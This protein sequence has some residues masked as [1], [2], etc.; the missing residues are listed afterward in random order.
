ML[1]HMT[2]GM[3]N[4]VESLSFKQM[5]C[6]ACALTQEDAQGNVGLLRME[7]HSYFML[8]YLAAYQLT[9]QHGLLHL[10]LHLLNLQLLK[11]VLLS[12]RCFGLLCLKQLQVDVR[13]SQEPSYTHTA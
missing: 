9:L 2:D 10:L 3:E 4:Y 13:K 11:V 6:M 1:H 12:K 5:P 7:R 8:L